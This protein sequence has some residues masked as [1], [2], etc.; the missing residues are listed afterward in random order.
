MSCILILPKFPKA[1]LGRTA[2]KNTT[3]FGGSCRK[4]Q[5]VELDY[6][7]ILQEILD[8]GKGLPPINFTELEQELDI[9]F[10]ENFEEI[11]G[12]QTSL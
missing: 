4:G 8:Y 6:K 3:A 5:C 9:D 7:I 12:Y 10:G 2:Q 11:R 1:L